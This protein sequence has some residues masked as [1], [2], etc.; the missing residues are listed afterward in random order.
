MIRRAGAWFAVLLALF[1]A[2]SGA[3]AQEKIRIGVIG[4][5]SG[6]FATAGTQFRMGIE[7]FTARPIQAVQQ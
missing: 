2:G 1:A 4:P 3:Q 7:A 6:P 5:F